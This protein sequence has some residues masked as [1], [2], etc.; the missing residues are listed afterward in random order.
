MLGSPR[1]ALAAHGARSRA[2]QPSSCRSARPGHS[3]ARASVVRARCA[4]FPRQKP[5]IRTSPP[6]DPPQT[7]LVWRGSPDPA[8]TWAVRRGSPDPARTWAV[9]RGS[10]D[11][12]RTWAVGG[13]SPDPART[14][15]EGL[16]GSPD[17][18]CQASRLDRTSRPIR[19]ARSDSAGRSG[20]G[21]APPAKVSAC[22]A[23][24]PESSWPKRSARV[25][26]QPTT[27]HDP[28]GA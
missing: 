1:Q 6:Y 16:P 23:P 26:K 11:P 28:G 15:T 5:R 25:R 12:A 3:A 17:S 18:R 10:P 4:C 22:L 13:G 2:S 9:G 8:W 27:F 21:G 20:S 14:S 19:A 24:S 7:V